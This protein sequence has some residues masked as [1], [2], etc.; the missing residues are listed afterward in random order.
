MYN[1]MTGEQRHPYRVGG[2]DVI[3]VNWLRGECGSC[4]ILVALET[5]MCTRIYLKFLFLFEKNV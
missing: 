3:G 2:D 1:V 5:S 4:K